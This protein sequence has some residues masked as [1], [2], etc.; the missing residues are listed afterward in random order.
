MK[1]ISFFAVLLLCMA[2]CS[3]STNEQR[4]Y[5]TTYKGK[6]LD[7]VAFPLG[8][9]GAGM[10]CI[11]GNGAISHVSMRNTPNLFFE[12]KMF[13]AISIK[14]LEHGAKVLESQVPDYKIFGRGGNGFG[15]G[16]KTYGLPRFEY[17]DFRG[18]FPFATLNLKDQDLPFDVKICA[19]SPFIPN[20][21]DNS[22]LPLACLEYS[23]TNTS[24][25]SVVAMYSFNSENLMGGGN[26]GFRN[27]KNGFMMYQ[28]FGEGNPQDEGYCAVYTDNDD[29]KVD[30]CWFR[31][32]WFDPLTMTWN[33][34]V[35]Q[36]ITEQPGVAGAPG[37][38]L[39]V[40][41]QIAPGETKTVR[42][43][44]LWYS[45]KTTKRAYS[46][47]RDDNER[48]DCYKPE[49]YENYPQ[50]YEPWYAHRFDSIQ[51]LMDYWNNN[52]QILRERSQK[53]ADAF[54]G[55]T[56]P[57][58]VIDAIGAN[59]TILK[60]P[61]ILRQHDGRLW[62]YEGSG[63]TWGSCDGTTTHVWNY[64]QAIPHLFPRLERTLR[65]TEHFVAQS[66]EGHQVFRV[67][68]PIRPTEHGF[69]AAADGQLGG[70]TKVYREWR[71]CGDDKWL[72]AIYPQVKASLDY[73]IRT[74]DPD[75]VGALLEPHHNTYDIE[76]WGADI[77]C[78]TFYASALQSFIAMSE[79][80]KQDCTPY[81][82]LLD[83]SVNYM[84]ENLWNGEY[85]IQKTQ[86]K[87]LHAGDPRDV[88]TYQGGY[89][90]EALAVLEKEGPKYQYGTGCISDGMI[91]CWMSLASGLEEPLDKE[92][93]KA[94]LD[95][96]YKYNFKTDLYDHACTQ[97][98]GYGGRH[99]AGT[100]LCS[101]PRGEKPSLPFVYS[102]EVWTGIE[103]EV[104]AHLIFE[105]EVE[106][107][108][109]LV[110]AVR[111]RYDGTVRN[112]YNEYECGNWYARALSS[113]SLLQAL[114]GIR[115]DAVEKTLYIDSRIGNTF[116]S[117]LSTAFGYATVGLK[118]G[119]PFIE[120]QEGDI[121]IEH[122]IVSGKEVSL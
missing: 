91:G 46:D 30:G 84:K 63:D 4:Q 20:D 100:L 119:K 12:P 60:S 29:T 19:W 121:P 7:H 23:F 120:I 24:Q 47:A 77:M 107:G 17:G 71:I 44:M 122:C 90:P 112:P 27:I 43:N 45:P 89:S 99:D 6:N 14:G 21:E 25:E 2:F 34:V 67:A 74:W 32:G 103:Y 92:L 79:Y 49:L 97:R 117:F 104:A 96:I 101:W 94:H 64:T 56:L 87:G 75:H 38:S 62:A 85:F 10:V 51:V 109:E 41:L 52:Y 98:P 88:Q 5:N 37:A 40:P 57:D 53:F 36:E 16:E 115:Y 58:E 9:L 69:H 82:E 15:I 59:L 66:S 65:E 72:Q 78:T 48:G 93:V 76:F 113:Y 13:S 105:G 28:N 81:K 86:W 8:G 61:T 102:D 11:E 110:R 33:K 42:L 35:S 54:Y 22:S 18:T 1:K 3:C 106:K 70:I 111:N 31:G 55:M 26:G 68:L 116:R 50:T 118:G 95:A 73:C 39:Y 83:K 108:L 114:T 80:L